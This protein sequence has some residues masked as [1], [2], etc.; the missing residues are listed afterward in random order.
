MLALLVGGV[1]GFLVLFVVLVGLVLRVLFVL[2]FLV[3]FGVFLAL[4]G[5][6]LLA[7][8]LFLFDGLFLVSGLLA[9]LLGVFALALAHVGVLK[10]FD[11]NI[12]AVDLDHVVVLHG[13]GLGVQSVVGLDG[14]GDGDAHAFD[15]EL[16]AVVH[17]DGLLLHL[18][19]K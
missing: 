7:L 13:V 2:F 8:F 17:L 15:L 12:L 14:L 18:L 11:R 6:A 10:L 9:F 16:R 19:A 4:G 5:V 1:L 3:L